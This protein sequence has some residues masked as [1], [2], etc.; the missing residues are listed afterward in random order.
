V[1]AISLKTV[2]EVGSHA[3]LLRRGGLY[4]RLVKEQARGLMLDPR[5]TETVRREAEA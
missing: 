4:A 5:S 1:V 2:A 3:E